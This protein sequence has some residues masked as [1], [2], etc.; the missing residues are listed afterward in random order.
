MRRI[1]P[2]FISLMPFTGV[3]AQTSANVPGD[4]NGNGTVT[5]A[6]VVT[7]ANHIIGVT[8]ETL[9]IENAD[10]N[11]DGV[12]SV[13]D[14]ISTVNI[15]LNKY[16]EDAI[17]KNQEISR[18]AD[19]LICGNYKC[20][21]GSLSIDVSLD[22]SIQYSSIQAD[23]KIPEGM[24]VSRVVQGGRAASHNMMYNLTEEGVLKIVLFS[25]CNL[26]F[27]DNDE[28]LF[29]IECSASADCGNLVMEHIIGSDRESRNYELGYAGG[30][31]EKTTTGIGSA[32]TGEVVITVVPEGVE[33]LNAEGMRAT[34]YS[35]AGEALKS[36]T[37]AADYEKIRLEKG[38]YIITVGTKTLKVVIP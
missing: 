17:I 34:V 2:F 27:Q 28:P 30:I 15:V 29:T 8:P 6:D 33:I 20:G 7:I 25:N 14:L 36:V 18:I 32:E 38:I 37:V 19:R 22:N 24:E 1:L 35:L 21:S 3:L 16:D 5:V 12:I 26:L 31:G 9:L 4:T 11:C 13:T 10:I 23:V